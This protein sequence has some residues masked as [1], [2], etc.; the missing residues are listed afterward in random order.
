MSWRPIGWLLILACVAGLFIVLFERG[1]PQGTIAALAEQPLLKMD[2]AAVTRLSLAT[3]E[4][5]AECALRNG[6]WQ[7]VSPVE[8]RADAATIRR[9]LSALNQ[10]MRREVITL[11]KQVKRGL[12]QASFGLDAPRIRLTVGSAARQEDVVVGAAVPLSDQVFVK[13]G[14][15]DYVIAASKA[16]EGAIPP[17]LDALRDRAVIPA[18][19]VR[20]NRLEIKHASGF[21]KLV[22]RDGGWRIQQ[23]QDARADGAA[24]ERLIGA[25]HG[26]RVEQ[27]V[28]ESSIVDP[29]A[30]GMGRDEAALELSVWQEGQPERIDLTVGK[31]SQDMPGMVYA[32][33]SDMGG[34]CLL[35]AESLLPLMAGADSL[36]DHRLCDAAPDAVRSIMLRDG[37]K[38]LAIMRSKGVGW[39]ITEPIQ[40]PADTGMVGGLLRWVCELQADMV[41][42]AAASNGLQQA[43]TTLVWQVALSTTAGSEG[44]TNAPAGGETPAGRTWTYSV[45]QQAVDGWRMVVDE[46][47]KQ[48]FRIRA[49]D[50]PGAGYGTA[51]TSLADP[52]IYM[53]RRVLYVDAASVRRL[54]LA[55][56][57]VEESVVRDASGKWMADSPPEAK[58]QEKT[59]TGILGMLDD[60]RAVGVAATQIGD[61]A[62]FGL[63]E[64]ALRLTLGL[65]GT[66]GIQKTLVFGHAAPDGNVY[67][68]LQGQ[69]VVFVLRKETVAALTRR[70]VAGRGSDPGIPRSRQ[71]S[72][73]QHPE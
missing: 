64:R 2:A 59:V 53:D 6:R 5:K 41:T 57:G 18:D 36:R 54:T 25:L 70:F 42:G 16:I 62:A 31:A 61:P 32:R 20:I 15:E 21:V 49:G 17:A 29:V 50:F 9:I 67:V 34:V 19:F 73:D 48:V 4:F 65:A 39:R 45:A 8:T 1:V 13:V 27:F 28:A 72:D 10:T 66:G 38:K 12:N 33:V 68:A 14:S 44:S 63:D 71:A 40:T 30:Y 22:F 52:L 56:G 47:A 69:D 58:V 7:M 23:L 11:E 43:G 24:V 3:P 60:V 51:G 46:E 37:E 35:A 26:L 55:S